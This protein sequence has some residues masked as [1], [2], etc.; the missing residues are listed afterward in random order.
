MKIKYLY[1][2]ILTCSDD[3]YYT[4][5]TNDPERRVKQHN[6]GID[7][8][9][10]TYTRPPVKMVYI[11]RFTDYKIAIAWEKRIKDWSRKKK[12]ALISGNWEKLKKEAACKNDTSH[13]QYL[14]QI[15]NCKGLDSARPDTENKIM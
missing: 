14:L 3:T 12:E 5:V 6:W 9:S 15:N 13:K 8:E 4:G 1:V 10:Y 7:K 2:Y 11:E